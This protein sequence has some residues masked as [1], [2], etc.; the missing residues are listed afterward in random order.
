MNRANLYD[1]LPLESEPVRKADAPGA[2]KVEKNESDPLP[3]GPFVKAK[4]QWRVGDTFK[5]E[6]SELAT[7]VEVSNGKVSFQFRGGSGVLL[8][9]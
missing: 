3:L 4:K 9:G 6:T 2:D 1:P 7:V 5:T 8:N